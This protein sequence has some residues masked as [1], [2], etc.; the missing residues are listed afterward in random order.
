MFRTVCLSIIITVHTSI[1]LCHINFADCL[2]AS[3]QQNLY[4]IYL[5]LCAQYWTPDDGQRDCSKHVQLHSK[6][7]FEKLVHLVGFVMI[8]YHDSRSSECQICMGEWSYSSA[9]ACRRHW[10]E[11]V[12]VYASL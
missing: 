4:G 11:Q 1:C 3:S 9:Y 8:I 2:L 10:M 12:V 5:L 6:N 7:K